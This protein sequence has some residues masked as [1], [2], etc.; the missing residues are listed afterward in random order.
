[1]HVTT[2]MPG[3]YG[4]RDFEHRTRPSFA[5]RELLGFT[6]QF[7]RVRL[8]CARAFLETIDHGRFCIIA[9]RTGSWMPITEG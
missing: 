8:F 9:E 1:M 2:V 7:A 6:D 5:S 4:S 3:T